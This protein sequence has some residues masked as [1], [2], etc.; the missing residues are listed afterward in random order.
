M[1][2]T[3]W[4]TVL[5]RD[6]DE[7]SQTIYSVKDECVYLKQDSDLVILA[8]TE[9]THLHQLLTEALNLEENGK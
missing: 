7:P 3:I 8:H 1:K 6:E 5:R 9:A 2:D 4:D